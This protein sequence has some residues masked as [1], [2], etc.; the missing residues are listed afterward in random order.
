M[1]CNALTLSLSVCSLPMVVLEH[2][3]LKCSSGKT[4]ECNC[5][6]FKIKS[7][8]FRFVFVLVAIKESKGQKTLVS[9]EITILDS[10]DLW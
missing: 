10:Y 4:P 7:N 6:I 5:S 1:E 9:K 3:L 2:D 8:V